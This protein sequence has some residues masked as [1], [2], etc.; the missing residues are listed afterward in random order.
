MSSQTQTR[1]SCPGQRLP[2][3]SSVNLTRAVEIHHL[4][5]PPSRHPARLV[6]LASK[7]RVFPFLSTVQEHRSMLRSMQSLPPLVWSGLVFKFGLS[8]TRTSSG[9]VF[10]SVSAIWLTV[11]RFYIGHGHGYGHRHGPRTLAL[12][13]DLAFCLHFPG[14][15]PLCSGHISN[16]LFLFH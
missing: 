15:S 8:A 13:F 12:N 6:S 2:S 16:L 3:S 1:R 7:R 9:H 14:E 10:L 5:L 11:Y 4:L